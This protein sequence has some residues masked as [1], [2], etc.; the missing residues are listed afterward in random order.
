MRRGLASK[1]RECGFI[2]MEAL[3]ALGLELSVVLE[4]RR[5]QRANGFLLQRLCGRARRRVLPPACN[6]PA[7]YLA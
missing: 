3:R 6:R 2:V 4:C 5:F 1:L 7:S